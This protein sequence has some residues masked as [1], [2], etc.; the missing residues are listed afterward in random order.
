MEHRTH[1][2]MLTLMMM[3]IREG[4][5]SQAGNDRTNPDGMA[6]SSEILVLEW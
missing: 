6:G 2:I 3:V 1:S 5:E 4:L